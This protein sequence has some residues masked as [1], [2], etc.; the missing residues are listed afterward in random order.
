M[1]PALF[2]CEI[3]SWLRKSL[4]DLVFIFLEMG[5]YFYYYESKYIN[6]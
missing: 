2:L 5:E 3:R 1:S 6:S 4:T